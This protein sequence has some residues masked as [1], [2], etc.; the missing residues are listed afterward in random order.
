MK[1]FRAI[2]C[3]IPAADGTLPLSHRWSVSSE[4]E[5]EIVA[6]GLMVFLR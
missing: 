5:Y 3:T 2:T 4:S 6:P 1:P